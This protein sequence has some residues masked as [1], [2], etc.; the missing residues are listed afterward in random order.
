MKVHRFVVAGAVCVSSLVSGLL[1]TPVAV[2]AGTLSSSVL[3]APASADPGGSEFVMP[4]QPDFVPR[5]AQTPRPVDVE[6]EVGVDESVNVV[7][8]PVSVVAVELPT[9]RR[10]SR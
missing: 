1:F 7:G 10:P 8:L 3:G 4:R 5:S 9:L 2:S 6:L